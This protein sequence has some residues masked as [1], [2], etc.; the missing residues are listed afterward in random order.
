MKGIYNI[1]VNQE[2]TTSF[3]LL[4]SLVPYRKNNATFE[5]YVAL[6]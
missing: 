1:T 3:N 2:K 6:F 4:W 5:S